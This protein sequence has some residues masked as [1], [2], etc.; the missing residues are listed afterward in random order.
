MKTYISDIVPKIQ[1]F[2]QRL[3]NITLL[4]NQ[5]WVVLDEISNSKNVYIFR[6]NNELLIARNGKV[7]KAKWE[8]L[9]HNALLI[10]HK[11]E[12][13]LFKH[14]FFDENILALKIDSKEEYAFLINESNFDRDLNSL[15]RVLEF[16]HMKYLAIPGQLFSKGEPGRFGDD[17][18]K[19]LIQ[20]QA[21]KYNITK[22]S[23]EE[24]LF[25]RKKD[26]FLVHFEDGITGEVYLIQKT[27]EAYYRAKPEGMWTSVTYYYIN[28]E[29]CI[30][31]LH[32]YLTKK[33]QLK[34]DFL[35]SF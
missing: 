13:Y 2:S 19:T 12:S 24:G 31:A 21:P 4:T 15:E 6:Q 10:D 29:S 27:K 23:V 17:Q 18:S 3:D 7:E 11:D 26:K 34:V 22:I 28:L 20:Y 35:G 25:V 33:V 14:G 9:G 32:H 5:H 1:R 16:L 30:T 8:Y